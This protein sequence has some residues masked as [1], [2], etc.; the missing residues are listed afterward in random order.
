MD[1]HV[2]GVSNA[3]LRD[4]C[5]GLGDVGVGYYPRSSFVHL[6]VR[7]TSAFWVDS[8]GPGEAPRYEASR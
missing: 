2:A 7:D 1:F 5:K 4:F 3:E 8:S 6:D